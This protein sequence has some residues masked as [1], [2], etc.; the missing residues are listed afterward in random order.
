[1]QVEHRGEGW[2]EAGCGKRTVKSCLSPTFFFFHLKSVKGES[3]GLGVR[4]PESAPWKMAFGKLVPLP[5]GAYKPHGS[6]SNTEPSGLP[7]G[8]RAIFLP[9]GISFLLQL[10][11][12]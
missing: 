2:A 12:L 5:L 6:S 11:K 1:M 10:G 4:W 9:R 3:L 8:G 7:K